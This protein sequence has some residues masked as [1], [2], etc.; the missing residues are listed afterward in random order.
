M[1]NTVLHYIELL[2]SIGK[3]AVQAVARELAHV[4]YQRGFATRSFD[5]SGQFRCPQAL[6]FPCIQFD[7]RR[8]INFDS[9]QEGN[10]QVGE[11]L[12]RQGSGY[13]EQGEE[14]RTS[15][16]EPDLILD[17]VVDFAA[18]NPAI[19]VGIIEVKE[20]RQVNAAT[21]PGGDAGRQANLR[22][23]KNAAIQREFRSVR[24]RL[25]IIVDVESIKDLEWVGVATPVE[26][27]Q[28]EGVE[29]NLMQVNHRAHVPAEGYL[30]NG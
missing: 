30:D 9:R 20:N 29:T 8:D 15:R 12:R 6:E 28:P 25:V 24:P 14:C 21:D 18:T 4:E 2:V 19:A 27:F 13:I 10:L 16:A 7:R 22:R 3:V 11:Q 23:G 1:V 5:F 26:A 17:K